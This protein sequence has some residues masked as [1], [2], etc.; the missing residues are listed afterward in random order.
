MF[1]IFSLRFARPV[2]YREPPRDDRFEVE[3]LSFSGLVSIAFQLARGG[4]CA[5]MFM[6]ALNWLLGG[7]ELHS[8]FGESDPTDHI[9][10]RAIRAGVDVFFF[11]RIGAGYLL[12]EARLLSKFRSW[13]SVR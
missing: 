9:V 3:K 4:T 2:G 12:G 10:F 8:W 13:R 5:F 6:L 11:C 7:G 1:S